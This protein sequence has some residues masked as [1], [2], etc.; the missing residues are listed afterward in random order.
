MNCDDLGFETTAS[1]LT[2][3]ELMQKFPALPARV[4]VTLFVLSLLERTVTPF[5]LCECGCGAAVHGKARLDSPAC[6]QRVSR[7]RRAITATGP[8][9]FGLVLQHEIP[10][11]IPTVPRPV[12]AQAVHGSGFSAPEPL[13][14]RVTDLTGRFVLCWR[15]GHTPPKT[16]YYREIDYGL[17]N[18]QLAGGTGWGSTDDLSLAKRFPTKEAALQQWRAVHAWPEDYEHCITEGTTWAAEVDCQPHEPALFRE[19]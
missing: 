15:S 8:K 16:L 3:T 17:S 13:R 1:A 6:R 14:N 10:V 4:V 12:P 2:V 9:Q 5:R 11:P 7:Q 18:S 19:L